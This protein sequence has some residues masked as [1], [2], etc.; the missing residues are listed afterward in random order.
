MRRRFLYAVRPL[1][2]LSV[3]LPRATLPLCSG[4]HDWP[5]PSQPHNRPRAIA[6]LL[7]RRHPIPARRHK[8]LQGLLLGVVHVSA[9]SLDASDEASARQL[10]MRWRRSSP[11]CVP[12]R[13]P[14]HSIH[15]RT[16]QENLAATYQNAVVWGA[17]G[18]LRRV[19]H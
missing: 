6:R 5:S 10:S 3:G 13:R 8:L 2:R 17:A 14:P 12:P 9:Q 11:S 18:T 4:Y 16:P 19:T 15:P 1:P 7:G